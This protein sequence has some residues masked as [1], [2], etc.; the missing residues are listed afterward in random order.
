[1]KTVI[2]SLASQYIH[3]SLAPWYL[4]YSAKE[5]CVSDVSVKVLEGTVNENADDL[6]QRIS[7][8]KADLIA[9]SC[10]IWNITLVKKL[11]ERLKSSGAKILLGGP[12]VS[13]NAKELL[14]NDFV[15]FSPTKV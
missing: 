10:Y 13:Y 7:A 2:V 1:M 8:E 6:I 14:S 4:Y 5:L 9:F 3:S 15:D 12:E 11:A